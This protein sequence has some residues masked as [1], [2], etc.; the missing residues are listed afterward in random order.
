MIENNLQ[1]QVLSL[2]GNHLK[3]CL[4]NFPLQFSHSVVSDSLWPH[5]PQHARPPC[6]SPNPRACSNSCPSSRWCHPTTSSS[7]VPF[8]SRLQTFPASVSFLLSQLFASGGQS[9][10]A[11]ASASVLPMNIQVW[12]HLRWTGWI[13]S[14]SK[15]PSRIFSNTTVQKHQ[16]YGAQLSLWSNFHIPTWLLEKPKLWLYGPLWAK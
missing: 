5:E 12:F 11:S 6:P 2:R 7:V 9:I 8:S 14:Q 4:Y 10:G 16:F 13:S 15:R 3:T 1:T